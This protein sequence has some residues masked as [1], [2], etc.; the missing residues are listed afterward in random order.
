MQRFLPV[1]VEEAARKRNR[2]TLEDLPGPKRT[3][4]LFQAKNAYTDLDFFFSIP[5]DPVLLPGVYY[6]PGPDRPGALGDGVDDPAA[7]EPGPVQ[8]EA[9]VAAVADAQ[10]VAAR[11]AVDEAAGKAQQPVIFLI[12][13]TFWNLKVYLFLF[14]PASLNVH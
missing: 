1:R 11:L 7:A 10:E 12:R 4:L 13:L 2:V 6:E 5:A 14:F 9:A 3:K 8:G